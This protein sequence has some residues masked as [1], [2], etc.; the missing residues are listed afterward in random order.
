MTI[1]DTASVEE[2]IGCYIEQLK[3]VTFKAVDGS[4]DISYPSWMH[5]T[6]L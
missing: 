5:K 6:E 4:P 3:D 1:S 2:F